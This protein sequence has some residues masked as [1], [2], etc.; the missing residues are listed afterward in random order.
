MLSKQRLV[1]LMF[2]P[3]NKAQRL[4]YGFKNKVI[5]SVCPVIMHASLLKDYKN[6]LPKVDIVFHILPPK[7]LCFNSLP[8]IIVGVMPSSFPTALIS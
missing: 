7:P 2:K 6:V 4:L 5:H 3:D 8:R 1:K